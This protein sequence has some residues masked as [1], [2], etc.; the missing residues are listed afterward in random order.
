MEHPTSELDYIEWSG[1]H[2]EHVRRPVIAETPWVFVIDGREA[3]RWMCSPVRLHC[4]ALGFLLNE[5]IISSAA[6]LRE[7]RVYLDEHRVHVVL[8][9]AGIDQLYHMF[10]C[11]DAGGTIVARLARPA[12]L[13]ERRTITS[14]CGGGITF[15]DLQRPYPALDCDLRVAA[16]QLVALMREL[17]YR[18]ELYRTSLG[19]AYL[20]AQRW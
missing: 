4:L 2:A 10:T 16:S 12:P 11:P 3:L 18:A 6:E 9:A 19:S 17:N 1:S 5:G 14:G 20:G 8:P 7:L 13:P 15:D